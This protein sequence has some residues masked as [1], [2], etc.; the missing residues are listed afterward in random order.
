[1]MTGKQFKAWVCAD[2]HII[3][4]LE[5]NDRLEGPRCEN[6]QQWQMA[7]I[8]CTVLRDPQDMFFDWD[9]LVPSKPTDREAGGA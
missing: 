7:T 4:P 1:M 5:E 2:C 8:Q 6:C 9:S 3:I